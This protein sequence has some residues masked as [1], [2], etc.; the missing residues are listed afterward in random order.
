MQTTVML[1]HHMAVEPVA[2]QE[3]RSVRLPV[4][5]LGSHE[6]YCPRCDADIRRFECG[7]AYCDL[8]RAHNWLCPAH[9]FAPAG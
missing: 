9:S 4:A 5:A 8:N 1:V 3:A 7:C 2:P 6:W